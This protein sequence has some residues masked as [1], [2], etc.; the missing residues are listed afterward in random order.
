[1]KRD[2]FKTSLWQDQMPDYVSKTKTPVKKEFD[3]LIVGGGVTGIAAALQLQKS[4]LQCVVTEAHNLC[5]GTTGGTTAHLNTF[6]D[7]DY[8]QI[9]KKF[10]EEAA[11]LIA[12]ATNQALDLYHANVEEFNIDCGYEQKDGYLYSQDEKQTEEL[13]RIFEASRKAGVDVAYTDRIPVPIEF[14]KAIVYHEQANIHPSKYVYALAKAFEERGGVILQNCT[15][16]SFKGDKLL[17][18]ETSQ[19]I[20]STRILIWATHIPPGIN[21]LHF[22]CAPYR[23]YAMAV[24]LNNDAYPDGLA[25][26]MYDPYHYY[27]TQIID[28]KKYLIAGGEDHKTAHEQNTEACFNKLE[29]HIRKYFDVKEVAFK[30]S[31]QYFEPADGLA[32]IGHLPGN[33]DSVLVAT[34]YGGNGMVYSHIAAITFTDLITKGESEYAKL[35]DPDRLKPI[36]GFANFVKENADVVKEFIGKRLSKEKLSDLSEIAPGE[37][38]L[39]KYEGKSLALYKDEEGELHAVSPVCPHAKCAVGWNNAEKSWDCPCHGSRFTIDGDVLTGPAVQGLEVVE[40]ESLVN[41]GKH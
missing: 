15:V 41:E 17:E 7:T 5:F 28:R 26:D 21:L 24:S 27:R 19:G 37:A 13:N 18:V 29:A 2:G 40:I 8:G 25:Y 9:A 14:E 34:G 10:D 16:K 38:K 23:S 6:L 12:K 3:V 20:F 35:F 36:S 31:S 33:P 30:W 22:R 1:M 4:G 32:Y 39:V 11:R